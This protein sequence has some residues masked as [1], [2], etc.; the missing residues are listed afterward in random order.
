MCYLFN[1]WTCGD[2]HV[3]I[4]TSVRDVSNNSSSDSGDI[5]L[6]GQRSSACKPSHPSR[7]NDFYGLG[8]DASLQLWFLMCLRVLESSVK[9]LF[10]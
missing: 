7:L 3:K 5:A 10:C 2:A 1:F 8:P 9:L 6:L 4:M